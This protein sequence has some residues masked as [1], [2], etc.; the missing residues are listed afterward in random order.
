MFNEA[1]V[2][3]EMD[4][5]LYNLFAI[6][7]NQY[8][9]CIFCKDINPGKQTKVLETLLETLE[10]AITIWNAEAQ[11][12]YPHA[13]SNIAS[14]NILIIYYKFLFPSIGDLYKNKSNN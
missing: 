5:L 11:M 6:N 3:G 7:F 12:L 4:V 13:D 10:Q 1:F 8:G 9:F 14:T 2:S